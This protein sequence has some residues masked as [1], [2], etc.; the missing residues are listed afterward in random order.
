MTVR[1]LLEELKKYPEDMVVVKE[2][3]SED[4]QSTEYEEDIVVVDS[5]VTSG[6][7]ESARNYRAVVIR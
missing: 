6:W 1:E 3:F 4:L 5:D 2:W 7:G